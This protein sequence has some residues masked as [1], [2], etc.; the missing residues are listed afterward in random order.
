MDKKTA[1]VTRRA[2]LG[3]V[4][5]LA[6]A[7][8]IGMS[9]PASAD[10]TSAGANAASAG[11]ASRIMTARGKDITIT[12]DSERC[13]HA[14]FCVL[15]QPHVY[16]ANVRPWIDPDAD[17][18]DAIA[19]VV[20][21]CPSGALQ[22]QRHDN[23]PPEPAPRVNLLYVRENG[24]VAVRA[25]MRVNGQ[26]IGYRA[27]LCRC[28]A[29]ETKPFCDGSHKTIGFKA[30]GEPATRESQPL[31]SR[32]GALTIVTIP[33]GPL[34]ARGNLEVCSGTARTVDRTTRTLLCRCGQ[35]RDK[36]FCDGSHVAAG[37]TA[38]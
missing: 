13:I 26:S 18:A 8:G 16:R 11:D 15:W 20:H 6:A 5:G 10:T 22:Y 2:L 23:G 21:A 12:F 32:G 29:S 14:R 34:E 31:E 33:N 19:A 27:T 4:S 37:F 35:S 28:G 24:P 1:S 3:G 30:G 7:S 17:S 9:R 36:P 25:D 38:D